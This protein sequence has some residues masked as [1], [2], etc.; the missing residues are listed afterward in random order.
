MNIKYIIHTHTHIQEKM[1]ERTH[2]KLTMVNLEE[3]EGITVFRV[4][5]HALKQNNPPLKQKGGADIR[6]AELIY[7]CQQIC[8]L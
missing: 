2:S 6:L 5:K 1:S 4:F 8:I 3:W 7:L